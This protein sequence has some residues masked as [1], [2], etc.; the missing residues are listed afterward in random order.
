M[1]TKKMHEALN[2]QINAEMYA[3]YL[4]L[5]MSAWLETQSFQGMARWMRAQSAEETGHAMRIFDYLNARG[6]EVKLLPIEAPKTAWKSPLEAFED[7]YAH[8]QKVTAMID[9]LFNLAAAEKDAASHDF[10]EWFVR[11]QVEEEAQTSLI[12][13]KLKMVGDKGPGLLMMDHALGERKED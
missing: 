7:A 6:A 3:S 1:L 5:S 12:V 9:G 13:A 11:E 8:E 10:L 2:Q 4:Y